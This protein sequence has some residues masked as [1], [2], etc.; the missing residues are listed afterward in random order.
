M[1]ERSL[2]EE[3]SAGEVL[4]PQIA[5]SL[6]SARERE[7]GGVELEKGEGQLYCVM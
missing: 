2:Q 4:L 7:R 3:E 5:V 6:I 1:F